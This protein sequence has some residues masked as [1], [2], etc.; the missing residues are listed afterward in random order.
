MDSIYWGKIVHFTL[1]FQFTAGDY[2]NER[3]LSLETDRSRHDQEMNQGLSFKTIV[4]FG[5]NAAKTYYYPP[6]LPRN[7]TQLSKSNMILIDS[8]GQYLGRLE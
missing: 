5:P 2:W 8:G 1:P 7:S 6:V 3:M 4:A